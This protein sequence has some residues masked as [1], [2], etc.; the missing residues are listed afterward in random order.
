VSSATISRGDIWLIQL[1]PALGAEMQKTRPVVVVSSDVIG[2]LP[3]KLVAPLTE[4]K[5]YFEQNPWHVK[6]VADAQNGL[7]KDSAVDV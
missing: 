1:D 6:V 5:T 4:W 7:S 3:I 2:V